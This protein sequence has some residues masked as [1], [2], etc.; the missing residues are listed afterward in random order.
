[1][2]AV[3]FLSATGFTDRVEITDSE[4]T[5]IK[6]TAKTL[7]V[8]DSILA[9]LK[10]T[11]PTSIPF[12]GGAVG[13]LSYDLKDEIENL[14]QKAQDD[15][16]IPLW[17]FAWYDGI[18]ICDHSTSQYW[19]AA[20][21]MD[22]QGKCIPKLAKDRLDRLQ[23]LID[24]YLQDGLSA[25]KSPEIP[26]P[27]TTVKESV[28]KEDYLQAITK[29]ID[30]IY[31]GDIYQ[32]NLTQRF[33]LVWDGD[34]WHLYQH[35]HSHNPAPFAAFLS[36]QD[37]QVLSSSPERFIR[38]AKNG[39]IETRP[40]KGTRPRSKDPDTDQKLANELLNSE[41]DKAELTMIVDLERNDLGRICNFGSVKVNDFM[42]L[43]K[44]P[45][46]WH[47]VSTIT[48]QT[49]ESLLPSQ[50]LRALFP[51]GSITGAPKIRAME[52]IEEMEPYKRGIYTGSI[53]YLGFDGAW[54]LNIV[55]RTIILKDGK[56]YVHVGG[57]I[58]AESDPKSEYAET[59][60]KAKALFEVLGGKVKDDD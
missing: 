24:G 48:G 5:E 19:L 34:P 6:Y 38:I 7:E 33:S 41:K 59:I 53:G 29:V 35:L 31:E 2:G 36:Y 17:R 57:G 52:I 14:P 56:A 11:N 20:C 47:L 26:I 15:L 43:E 39:K 42:S 60:T 23:S 46:V 1:M 51:G 25:H 3:P 22:E 45:T 16:K 30:Y 9:K 55:I 13:Y 18:I 32:A 21:G 49:E 4:K 54:D 40:I 44:Y 58:V 8:L 50:I 28:S 12:V 27:S 37:F 10:I